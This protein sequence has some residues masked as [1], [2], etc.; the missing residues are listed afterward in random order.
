MRRYRGLFRPSDG[1]VTAIWAFCLVAKGKKSATKVTWRRSRITSRFLSATVHRLRLA[2][3]PPALDRRWRG[4]AQAPSHARR[5][6]WIT[7][8]G[9]GTSTD[10]AGQISRVPLVLTSSYQRISRVVTDTMRHGG[11]HSGF[12]RAAPFTVSPRNH[13]GRSC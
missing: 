1:F 3:V 13:Y 2:S 12:T 8:R 6:D 10:K 11:Q 4:Q 5:S 9:S 7:C